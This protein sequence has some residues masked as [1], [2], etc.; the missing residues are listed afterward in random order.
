[1][2]ELTFLYTHDE[3]IGYGRMG[4][5]IHKA[6]T[7]LGV[8]VYTD[9][10]TPPEDLDQ[11]ETERQGRPHKE[12]HTNVVCWASV[13]SHAM[14]WH[15]GQYVSAFTMWEASILPPAFRETFPEFDLIIVPSE[16]NVE[17]FS[18]Y[19]DNVRLNP[20]GVD[21]DTWHYVPRQDPDRYFNFLIGGSGVRK[22]TDLAF[23]A[24]RTV[25][26][27]WNGK[28]PEPTLIMKNPKGES[29]FRGYDRVLMVSGRITNQAEVDLYA[30]AH[31]YVQPSRGEGFGL[32]PLQ[33]MAQGCPTI[34]TNA[35][36]HSSFAKYGIPIGWS[37][38]EADYFIYG[39]AGD[40]WEPDFEELCEAMWDVYHNYEPHRLMAEQVAKNVVPR[41]FL[42]QHCAERFVAAHDGELALPYSGSGEFYKPTPR[43]FH[44]RVA[45]E[46]KAEVAGLVRIWHPD[47]D[48][49][50]TADMKRILF[51]R[52]VLDP[53]CLQGDDT[54]LDPGQVKRIGAYSADKEWCPTCGQQ[55]NS[56]VQRSDVIY[57]QMLAESA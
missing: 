10:G 52:G 25:F 26:G 3:G 1:M 56:G 36:G 47:K 39:F 45:L 54:G 19:H 44:V 24:F 17:L 11:R 49:Y 31:C 41:H 35:H 12:G 2:N 18:K 40:W 42:W 48:Y 14:W 43:L 23:K 9:L 5:A 37:M 4:V 20:L 27:D 33:A 21:P 55:L 8:D 7:D 6:L 46:W 13:P 51:E 28:G 30:N 50:E 29:Q 38:K 53:S 34:L 22:G 16:Q 15:E 32:Q 57:E